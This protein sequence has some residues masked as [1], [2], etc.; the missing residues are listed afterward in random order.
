MASG[1]LQNALQNALA[2]ESA[3]ACAVSE[4]AFLATIVLPSQF[5]AKASLGISCFMN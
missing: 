2:E 1:S 3:G 4:A 5:H